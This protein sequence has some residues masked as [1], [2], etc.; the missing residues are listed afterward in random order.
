MEYEIQHFVGPFSRRLTLADLFLDFLLLK[1]SLMIF[2]RKLLLIQWNIKSNIF[3]GHL[4][5]V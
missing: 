1:V 2:Q 5:A 4:V 3:W